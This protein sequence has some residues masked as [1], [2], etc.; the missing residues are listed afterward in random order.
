MPFSFWPLLF[1]DLS[2]KIVEFVCKLFDWRVKQKIRFEYG[3]QIMIVCG[4]VIGW[5]SKFPASH[6]YQK[7]N[8]SNTRAYG[9]PEK[10]IKG[11]Q[12]GAFCQ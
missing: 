12:L 4:W 9:S 10:I 8:V 7:K 5:K 1:K 2:Q 11:S 6:L 3:W